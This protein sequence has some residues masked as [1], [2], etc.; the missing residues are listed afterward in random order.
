MGKYLSQE[1]FLKKAQRVHGNKYDYTKS[2]YT[3]CRDKIEIVC[4]EHGSFYQDPTNHLNLKQGCPKC[5][6]I[7]QRKHRSE[8]HKYSVTLQGDYNRIC[9]PIE[10]IP[11]YS[12]GGSIV[13]LSSGHLKEHV[14]LMAK[15]LG[16]PIDVKTEEVHHKNGIKTDNRLSNLELRVKYH[17]SGQVVEDRVK[18]AIS[19]LKKYKPEVL[20]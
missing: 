11:L 10:E 8:P 14:Y 16:R 20:K 3:G 5:G 9:L 7:Q 6:Q 13:G 4:S 15:H 17:G 19:L 12:T 18:D 1:D 2:V